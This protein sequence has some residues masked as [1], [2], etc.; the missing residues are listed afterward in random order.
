VVINKI[1]KPV[2]ALID[3][4]RFERLRTLDEEYAR[5]RGELV[6]AFSSVP[7]GGGDGLDR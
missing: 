7:A 2:A 1:G 5:L 4:E 6:Q 3:I